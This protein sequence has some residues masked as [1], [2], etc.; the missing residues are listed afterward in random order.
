MSRKIGFLFCLYLLISENAPAAEWQRMRIND[1]LVIRVEIVTTPREQSLGMGGRD[2]FPE[3]T[4]MLFVYNSPGERI[5]WMKRMR[6][7]IDIVW[8]RYGKIVF[9][10][11]RVPPPPPMLNERFLKRYGNGIGADMVLELPA[12]YTQKQAITPGQSIRM[13]P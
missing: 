8:I 6:I 10:Q 11:P 3:G 4:G 9:I 5:F 13:I 7:P 1:R 2:R 12:G